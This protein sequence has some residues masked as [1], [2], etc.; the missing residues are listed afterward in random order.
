MRA[1]ITLVWLLLSVLLSGCAT[2]AVR[3]DGELQ[4]INLPAPTAPRPE[5]AADP[6][7]P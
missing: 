6:A 5:N 1:P 4:P 2:R 7:A 3:C